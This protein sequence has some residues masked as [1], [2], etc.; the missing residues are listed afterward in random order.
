MSFWQSANRAANLIVSTMGAVLK[1]REVRIF[2]V[3][4]WFGAFIA[5]LGMVIVHL[6]SIAEALRALHP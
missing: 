2:I 4:A 1:D 3:G 5:I 6:R